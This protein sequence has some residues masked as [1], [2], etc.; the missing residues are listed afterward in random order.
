V[1]TPEAGPGTGRALSWGRTTPYVVA[2]GAA[3]LANLA[4]IPLWL[5]LYGPGAYGRYAVTWTVAIAAGAAGVGWIRQAAMRAAGTRSSLGELPGWVAPVC[6]A[7]TGAVTGALAALLGALTGPQVWA[8]VAMGA[9]AAAAQLVATVLQR[10]D[11]GWRF[12]ASE[13]A[14]VLVTLAVTLL[15]GRAV[16]AS[17]ALLLGA[18]AGNA[19]VLGFVPAR[20]WSG[21][22]RPDALA[23]WWHYGWPLSAW[24]SLAPLVLY[25]DRLALQLFATAGLVGSFAALSDLVVRGL[26]VL[27]GPLVT[28][29]SIWAMR[30]YNAGAEG[31]VLGEM[32]RLTALALVAAVVVA[33]AVWL[34]RGPLSDALGLGAVPAVCFPL[35]A[36]GGGLWQAAMFA[37]KPLELARRTRTML[38]LLLLAVAVEAGLCLVLV[39]GQGAAGAATALVAGVATYVVA[40]ALATGRR[41]LA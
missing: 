23:E 31:H 17:A 13:T 15:L 40:S 8:G 32:R 37:H 21:R 18:A 34:V 26:A 25:T 29:G 39:P 1:R 22:T 10:D 11:R 19:V 35:L 5:H 6:V 14:R 4:M 27:G 33:V 24:L 2:A 28:S 12:A 3:G 38:L 30:E 16:A 20:A 41:R 7:A 9:S 36:L